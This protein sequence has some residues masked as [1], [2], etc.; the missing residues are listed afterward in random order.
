MDALNPAMAPA[1]ARHPGRSSA[2]GE[3]VLHIVLFITVLTSSIAFIEPS[4]TDALMFV[5]LVACIAARVR[6]DPKLVPLL[7]LIVLW[8]VGGSI[9]TIMDDDQKSYQFLGTSAYLDISCV[10]IACLYC[11][12]DAVRLSILRRAYLLAAVIATVAGYIGWFHLVPQYNLFLLNGR[13]SA[14]FK[15]PN[16]YGPFLIFPLLML[17]LGF[18]TRR[19]TLIGLTVMLF[20]LGGLL[21]S[22]S[23]GAWMHF[24]VSSLVAAV[25]AYAVAPNSR[26]RGRIIA[27]SLLAAIVI[28]VLVIAL[29]S[30]PSVYETFLDRAKA[31]EPYDVGSAGRFTLQKIALTAILEHPLGMGSFKFT[32]VFGG[33]QHNVYMQGFIVYGW[34]G[35]AAYLTLV[36]LTLLLGLRCVMMPSPWRIY[37]IA[38]FAAY[39]GEMGEGSIIDSDHWRHFFLLVGMV[40]GLSVANLNWRRRQMP[41]EATG[42][43]AAMLSAAS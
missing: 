29:L 12:G 30:I 43:T 19:V 5:L 37:L 14:T 8:F 18:L 32:D 7:M 35:G 34:L 27:I 20:L 2:A 36:L 21:L 23:R 39:I 6:F 3:S 11:D 24:L 13:V 1:F 25:L 10:M 41:T 31:I 4:P 33:Q 26:A 22:F 16:V 17:M 9:A 15:D 42:G 38:A 28:A 40:W